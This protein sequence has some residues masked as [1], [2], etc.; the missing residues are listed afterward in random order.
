MLSIKG[1]VDLGLGS[2]RSP[3][4]SLGDPGRGEAHPEPVPLPRMLRDGA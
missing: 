3:Q 2:Q 1:S 4:S